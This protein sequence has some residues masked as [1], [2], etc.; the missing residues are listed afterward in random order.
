MLHLGLVSV[1]YLEK[2]DNV[3]D[4]CKYLEITTTGIQEI[5]LVTHYKTLHLNSILL[6]S[7]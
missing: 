7:T 4:K 3:S 5:E 6:H 1:G 2:I